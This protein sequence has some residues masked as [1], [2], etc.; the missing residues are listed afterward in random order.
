MDSAGHRRNIL[1]CQYKSIG[2][3]YSPS[4]VGKYKHHWVQNF[5]TV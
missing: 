2:V 3:G 1:N 5:G 4:A